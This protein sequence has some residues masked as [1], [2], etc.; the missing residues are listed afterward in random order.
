MPGKTYK[1][2]LNNFIINKPGPYSGINHATDW[3]HGEITRDELISHIVAGRAI[4]AHYEHEYRKTDNFICCDFIAA[5]IDATMTLEEAQANP[6]VRDYASFIYTT[7]SHSD[8]F[9]RFRI[10][11]LLEETI[12]EA[13]DW[14]N[15]LAGLG[16]KL[17]SDKS[18][19]D[20]G[21]LFYGSKDATIIDIG[22]TLSG[23]EA[24]LLI[25]LGADCRR[26]A[27]A[28]SRSGNGA[29]IKSGLKL[30]KDTL[31]VLRNGKSAE[32]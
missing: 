22:N 19:K 26:A 4:S 11:F 13:K 14:A 30:P 12:T 1:I 23:A 29:P 20:A 2:G 3:I 6:F 8:E 24:K 18:V 31:V 5:D 15:C 7:P 17:D 16:L 32:L 21:R 28:A 27:K 9:H 10:V 25:E